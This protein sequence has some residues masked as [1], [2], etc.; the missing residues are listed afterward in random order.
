MATITAAFK[1]V[2][3]NVGSNW[4]ASGVMTCPQLPDFK[5]VASPDAPTTTVDLA[6]G[7]YVFVGQAYDNQGNPSGDPVNLPFHVDA[8]VQTVT[9][10]AFDGFTIS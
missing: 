8:P 7:D 1:D 3:I 5:F 9:V 10:K 2:V 4:V 6:P